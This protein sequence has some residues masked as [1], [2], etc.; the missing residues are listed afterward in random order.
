MQAQAQLSTV[1]N[2]WRIRDF[3]TLAIFNVVMIIIIT[4]CPIFTVASYL[5]VGGVTA[6]LNGPIYMVMSNK[7]DKRG[8]LFFTALI[9]GLYFMAYGYVYFLVTLA[10]IGI[11]SELVVWGGDAYKSPVRN[12]IGYAIFYVGYSLCGVIPLIFFREQYVEV[13]TKSYSQAALDE[14]L[15]YYGTP[16]IVVIMCAISA[17][18]AIIGCLAGNLLLKKHVKKAKLV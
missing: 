16:S 15:Y 17:A 3:I 5:I 1:Q 14:M 10:V 7:I 6:L 2:R 13:L 8:I 18:G 12:A 9:T 4:I 11:I